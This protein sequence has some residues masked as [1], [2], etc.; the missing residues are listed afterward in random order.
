MDRFVRG[1]LAGLMLLVASCDINKD[2]VFN[3]PYSAETV[4]LGKKFFIEEFCAEHPDVNCHKVERAVRYTA[5]IYMEEVY[6]LGQ[7]LGGVVGVT[8][9]EIWVATKDLQGCLR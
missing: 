2:Q 4:E 6:S 9:L 8:G 1:L 5:I 3:S 7:R